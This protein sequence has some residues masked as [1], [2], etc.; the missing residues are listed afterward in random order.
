MLSAGARRRRGGRFSLLYLDDDDHYLEDHGARLLPCAALWEALG[1]AGGGAPPPLKGRLRVSTRALFFEPDDALVP[2]LRF[3]FA[4]LRALETLSE[5]E[6]AHGVQLSAGLC[7][8]LHARRPFAFLKGAWLPRVQLLHTPL[9][10]VLPLLER[11]HALARGPRPEVGLE[12]VVEERAA[13][14][15]FDG[16]WLS[17]AVSETIVAEQRVRWVTPLVG[18]PGVLALTK[19]GLYFQCMHTVDS[20]PQARWPVGAVCGVERK[21][22]LLRH[23]A[24]EIRFTPAHG[25]SAGAGAELARGGAPAQLGGGCGGCGADEGVRSALLSSPAPPSEL[26][27]AESESALFA[28][29][30]Q[31]ERDAFAAQLLALRDGAAGAKAG[32]AGP[33][34]DG[35]SGAPP[36]PAA[37]AAEE[38]AR[39]FAEAEAREL[40]AAQRAWLCGALSSFDYLMALNQLSGRSAHDL[41][42]YP[43]LPWVLSDYESETVDLA[44]PSAYRD[45]SKPVSGVCG[46]PRG[47]T[48]LEAARLD[49]SARQP[50]APG[51]RSR[52]ALVAVPRARA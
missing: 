7:T 22:H 34:C 44:Q 27:P 48:G 52:P 47:W 40:D 25:G 20:E 14:F 46:Q 43:V 9:A 39:R 24:L 11:L 21:R 42:Q 6:L 10:Q 3:P 33:S 5:P 16:T 17:D 15:G 23:T 8:E 51:A 1:H 28:F 12:A 38:R 13:G 32:A 4:Q 36:P 35:G 41:S 50:E 19:R 45:L 29:Q 26:P 18:A 49:R 2:V 30:S 37:G 31:A